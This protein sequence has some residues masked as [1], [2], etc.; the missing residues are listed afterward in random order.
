MRTLLLVAVA[1]LGAAGSADAYWWTGAGIGIGDLY[2][3]L[4]YPTERRVPYFA[5]HPPVYYSVPVP[6]TYGYS[7]FAYTPDT[8]TPDVEGAPC[9]PVE[10]INP[11]VPSSTAPAAEPAPESE[12]KVRNRAV[13]AGE[14]L[15]TG[16]AA[17]AGEEQVLPSGVRVRSV[18]PKTIVN[19]YATLGRT[20]T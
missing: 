8:R 19:P 2:R 13:S 5:A 1:T 10:I 9:G 6:R 12:A 15:S 11:Y 3:S 7:P 14:S 17:A 16:E 18:G 20:A 4:D